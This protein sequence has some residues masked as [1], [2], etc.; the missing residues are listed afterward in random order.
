M[1]SVSRV[2][3]VG[4]FFW[5]ASKTSIINF[6]MPTS[7]CY[8]CASRATSREHVPPR[9]LFPE[10]SES[11][12]VD[13]RLNLVT[14]PSCDAHNSAKSNDDEFLMV[15]LA[16][17]FGSNSIGFMHRL[18]KVDRAVLKSASRLLDQV[19]LE[20]EKIH[21]VEIAEN[22]FLDLIWGTPRHPSSE[23]LLRAHSVRFASVPLQA[24]LL[25]LRQGASGLPT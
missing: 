2:A 23:S 1:I 20:K 18:G 7:H 10:A 4:A 12:G 17:I 19:L 22:E 3:L 14:V 25:W 21:R 13:Y 15:S 9:N 11:G 6:Q 8:R 16:G 5:R 24:K